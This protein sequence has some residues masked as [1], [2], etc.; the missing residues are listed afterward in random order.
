MNT[1][2]HNFIQEFKDFKL[3]HDKEISKLNSQLEQRSKEINELQN[4]FDKLMKCNQALVERLK[5]IND[6]IL[7]EHNI[8][9]SKLKFDVANLKYDSNH[10]IKTILSPE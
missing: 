3:R 6:N 2:L 4:N 7:A 1:E 9:I 5:W 8:N 10:I